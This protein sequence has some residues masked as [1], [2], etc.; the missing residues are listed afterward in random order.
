MCWRTTRNLAAWLWRVSVRWTNLRRS[1]RMHGWIG[2]K[3]GR[4]GTPASI[5]GSCETAGG[6]GAVANAVGVDVG[7]TKIRTVLVD[8]TGAVLGED[9]RPTPARDGA[10][11]ILEAVSLSV[12]AVRRDRGS[13]GDRAAAIRVIGVGVP[14]IVDPVHGTAV[15]AANLSGWRN[16]PVVRDLER[17]FG[18]PVR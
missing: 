5:C 16:V 4:C 9:V 14:G 8:A 3:P 10:S 1:S 7:G 12:E 2:T 18:V 15:R 11:A 13:N 17:R 6:K